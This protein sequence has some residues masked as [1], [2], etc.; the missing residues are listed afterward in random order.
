MLN[1]GED[2]SM[3]FKPAVLKVSI[4]D[5]I[6]FKATDLAHNSASIDGMVPRVRRVGRVPLA[7]ILA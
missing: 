2:G 1:A 5:T 4:G 3:V 6:H 7:Q